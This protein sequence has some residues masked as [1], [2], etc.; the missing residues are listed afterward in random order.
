MGGGVKRDYLT[1]LILHFA[2]NFA[3]AVTK[4]LK[5]VKSGIQKVTKKMTMVAMATSHSIF[6]KGKKERKR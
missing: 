4:S 1:N 5:K 6:Q 2:S 3:I